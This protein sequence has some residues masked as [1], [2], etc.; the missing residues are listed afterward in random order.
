MPFDFDGVMRNIGALWAQQMPQQQHPM[1]GFNFG[2]SPTASGAFSFNA[3]GPSMPAAAPAAQPTAPTGATALAQSAQNIFLA[4]GQTN[5][6]DQ[7]VWSDKARAAAQKYNIDPDIFDAQM[8]HESAGY[9]PLVIAGVRKSSA[10]AT[11]IAQLMPQYHP[12]VD[13]TDPYASL[14]YAAN[15][16]SSHLKNYG[17][18]YRK[19]LVAYNGGGGAVNQYNAGTPYHESQQYLDSVLAPSPQLNPARSLSQDDALVPDQFSLKDQ[20]AAYAACGPAAY[21]ALS[22]LAGHPIGLEEAVNMAGHFGWDTQGGMNGF[23]NFAKMAQAG[24]LPITAYHGRND[25]AMNE[26]IGKGGAAVLS[27]PGHYF[28]ATKIDPETGQYFV[29]NSGTAYKKGK[30]WMSLQEMQN[31]AGA[32]G[33]IAT[34]SP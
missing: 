2:S 11:G 3:Q 19:A 27:T 15:L 17:G 31:L 16:M 7:Q 8:R 9:D 23:G 20:Q 24:G 10:G 21:A 22:K 18:D 26:A 32:I 4:K 33:D 12:N 6:P 1:G 28:V 13:P 25:Q 34:Y 29:G 14:D 30:P 5:N